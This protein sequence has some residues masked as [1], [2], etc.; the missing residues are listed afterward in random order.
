MRTAEK[1]RPLKKLGLR[2]ADRHPA[3]LSAPNSMRKFAALRRVIAP[4]D[5][6][7]PFLRGRF[8]TVARPAAK[9]AA[10]VTFSL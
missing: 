7:D 3:S 4:L 6:V 1:V 2:R 5:E 10:V 9:P 8:A